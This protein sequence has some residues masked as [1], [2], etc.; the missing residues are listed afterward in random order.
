MKTHWWIISALSL[1]VIATLIGINRWGGIDRTSTS[2]A[3]KAGRVEAFRVSPKY[4]PERTDGTIGGYPIV[5]TGASL[6]PEF[7][8]RLSTVLRSWGVSNSPKKSGFEPAIAFRLWDG[9]RA[10][11]VLISFESDTLWAHAVEDTSPTEDVLDFAPVRADLV[12]LVKEAFPDN[13]KIQ[14][15]TAVRP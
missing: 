1:A 9:D 6:E 12:A 5:A 14:A 3:R 2:I 10:L 4:T 13:S 15:L 11:D 7:A 8:S